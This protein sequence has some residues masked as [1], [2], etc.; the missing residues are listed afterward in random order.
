MPRR[1]GPSEVT[2]CNTH[3]DHMTKN[4]SGK[5][6]RRLGSSQSIDEEG[7]LTWPQPIRSGFCAGTPDWSIQ[8][9]SAT[10]LSPFGPDYI[11]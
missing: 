2:L 6:T 9:T 10:A 4:L 3:V 8:G 11:P 1:P 7:Q 5:E